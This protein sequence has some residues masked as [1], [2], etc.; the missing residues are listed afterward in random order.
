MD[1]KKCNKE[2]KCHCEVIINGKDKGCGCSKKNGTTQENNQQKM[3]SPE[4]ER[5][6]GHA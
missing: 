1:E 4:Y 2:C 3:Q 6:D 5:I